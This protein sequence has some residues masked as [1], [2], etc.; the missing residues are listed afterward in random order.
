MT[1]V[2]QD[3][4]LILLSNAINWDSI[5]E[6]IK[7]LY[8]ESIGRPSCNLRQM[9]GLL[10]LQ[11]LFDYSDEE[12]I[13]AW[14]QNFYYQY[15]TGN[16]YYQTKLPCTP[17]SLCNFRKKIKQ[18]GC[19]AIFIESINLHGPDIFGDFQLIDTTV[20]P[21]YTAFPTDSKLILDVI[22]KCYQFSEHLD[23]K[24]NKDYS[25]DI[26]SLKKNINFAKGKG[27]YEVKES[28][29]QSLRDIANDLLDQV[30]NKAIVD[31]TQIELFRDTIATYRKAVNQKKNDKNKVYS[32]FE[33]VKC[34]IKGKA[35]AKYEYG[36]KVSV[37]ITDKSKIIVGLK[38]FNSNIYDGDTIEPTLEMMHNNDICVSDVMGGDLGFRGRH[39]ILG[40]RI[41]TP[42]SLKTADNE[43]QIDKI[44]EI[45]TTRSSIEPV[46]GHIKSDHRMERNLLHGNDGDCFN[47]TM[48]AAA[49]NFKKFINKCGGFLGKTSSKPP[50]NR[51]PKRKTRAVPF[52]KPLMAS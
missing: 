43:S 4:P 2:P 9:C 47:A 16:K 26:A 21:K 20:Q 25:Q 6:K 31:E 10:I 19:E 29:I 51:M 15:F 24:F 17:E 48:A 42:D 41:I 50:K 7:P 11:Y 44:R 18:Q 22:N 40:T 34:Y 33:D 39:L 14:K 38:N 23:F 8:N 37:V 52:W 27:S 1:L 36:S 28:Y 32:I 35:K 5:I 13:Y 3:D 30:E 46:I 49:F 12:V 45:L